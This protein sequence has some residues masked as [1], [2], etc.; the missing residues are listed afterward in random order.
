MAGDELAAWRRLLCT[1]EG[2]LL[3]DSEL[4]LPEKLVD[5]VKWHPARLLKA[6]TVRD[7]L[8]WSFENPLTA[9]F[10][11]QGLEST[12]EDCCDDALDY[13]D[14]L[15]LLTYLSSGHTL[16]LALPIYDQASE[17]LEDTY[18]R[19]YTLELLHQARARLLHY[20]T[21]MVR[22]FRPAEILATLADSVKKFPDNAIF[23]TLYAANLARFNVTD[24]IRDTVLDIEH[25]TSL[26]RH[27]FAIDHAV[28]LASDAAGSSA[29]YSYHTAVASFERAVADIPR[30]AGLWQL[31][32]LFSL[33]RR[34]PPGTLALIHRAIRA[35][36][37][38]KAFYMFAFREEIRNGVDKKELR[39]LFRVMTEKE[40]R[41]HVD[42]EAHLE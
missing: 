42:L 25:K 18:L 29:G 24:R 11:A 5:A 39:E 31:Y 4:V 1:P 12:D 30:A 26:P 23:R 8:L 9:Q 41:V 34:D 32:L 27:F 16:R 19:P 38:A 14:L 3:D 22:T 28:V 7:Q 2:R 13:A 15:A 6:R 33:R 17:V 35:C 36:P 37:W 21:Q 20:H 40:L 10:L